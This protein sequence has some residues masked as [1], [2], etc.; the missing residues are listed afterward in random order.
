MPT[1]PEDD[2]AAERANPWQLHSLLHSQLHSL[3]LPRAEPQQRG[4]DAA[5]VAPGQ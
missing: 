1:S 2:A 4:V 5:A 3:G